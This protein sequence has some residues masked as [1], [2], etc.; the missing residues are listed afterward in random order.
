MEFAHNRPIP[1]AVATQGVDVRRDFVK[2][3]YGHLAFAILAFVAL[4]YLLFDIG[5]YESMTLWVIKGQWNW[6]LVIGAFMAVGWLADKW[7][8]SDTSQTMQYVGL[9]L[10]V[11]A[12]AFI[13]GPLLYIAA[14]YSDPSVIPTAGVITLGLFAGL[15]ATV[16][17]TKKD[18]S[19]L[20]GALSIGFFVALALIVAG[21]LFG[22]QLGLFFAG[23]MIL[24]AAGAILYQT[25]QILAHYHPSAYV[26]AALGLF[27][28]VAL[29]FYYVL[30]FVMS[31]SRD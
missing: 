19:F 5:V 13:F 16:F 11:V 12:E 1:G 15:T 9:G 31:M 10:Y 29:L 26:A 4:C 23:F 2:K 25:S 27:A 22:F 8:R 28:S 6:L 7:A 17:I 21:V 3:T 30:I 14:V 20:R 24:L 18:F